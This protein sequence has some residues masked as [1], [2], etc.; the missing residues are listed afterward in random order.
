MSFWR[1]LFLASESPGDFVANL[2]GL[3]SPRGQTPEEVFARMR[4]NEK[5]D[6]QNHARVKARLDALVRDGTITDFDRRFTLAV[7]RDQLDPPREALISP[8][9]R[10]GL[11][12]RR[13]DPVGVFRNAYY[14]AELAA[15]F[16]R[17]YD[18]EGATN[19]LRASLGHLERLFRAASGMFLPPLSMSDGMIADYRD[20]ERSASFL[21]PDGFSHVRRVLLA[22]GDHYGQAD[23]RDPNFWQ[24]V[25]DFA[26]QQRST[27]S[28]VY[29]S[30]IPQ[31]VAASGDPAVYVRL[32][33]DIGQMPTRDG[34]VYLHEAPIE[35]PMN[36][37]TTA[38]PAGLD[39]LLA[40]VV[41][42]ADR[43][44]SARQIGKRL[45]AGECL[46]LLQNF[47]IDLY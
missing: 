10:Q 36:V 14:G 11:R 12:E 19:N 30:N 45:T 6:P 35:G 39:P 21:T 28:D 26:R 32:Q 16:Q 2:A 34:I 33:R 41:E 44:R 40:R 17:I 8:R 22:G 46:Y 37:R 5:G 47:G 24:A 3:S 43:G 25:G 9:E 42:E 4:A 1:P 18:V 7:L 13:N 20:R 15:Q 38:L 27:V 29:T 23:R 31:L